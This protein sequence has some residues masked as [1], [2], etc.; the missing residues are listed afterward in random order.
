MATGYLDNYY[1][2]LGIPHTATQEEIRNAYHLAARKFHPDYNKDKSAVE[3]FLQ[4]QEA[5]ETLS[6]ATARI[7]Y[8]RLLPEDI[9]TPK[10][11]LVNAIYSRQSLTNIDRPQLLYVLLNIVAL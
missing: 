6:N 10:D 2:R 8:D 9:R 11:I 5:Y 3:V 7:N 4:I 1:A